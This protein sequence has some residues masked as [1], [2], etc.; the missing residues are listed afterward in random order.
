MDPLAAGAG[1]CAAT[2]TT[3]DPITIVVTATT[4]TIRLP[5]PE[6]DTITDLLM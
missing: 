4:A 3:A 1:D 2:G 6:M 5:V